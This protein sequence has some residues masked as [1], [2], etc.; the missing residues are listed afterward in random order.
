[1]KKLILLSF[2]LMTT[3]FVNAQRRGGN[4][5][6]GIEKK[7]ANLTTELN[8]STEQQTALKEIFIEQQ[9][10]RRAGGKNMRDLDQA[11]RAAMKAERKD[12]RAAADA[13]IAN[14]LTPAQLETFKH[15]E[16]EKKANRGERGAAKGDK[17]RGKGKGKGKAK[18]KGNKEKAT[19]EM[20]AQKRADKLTE[21]LGLNANQQ[22]AV[23]NLYL[24]EQPKAKKGK[25]GQLSDAEKATM[26][27]ERQQQKAAFEAELAQILTPAQFEQFQNMPKKGK[28]KGK[29]NKR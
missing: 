29:K 25:R 16:T 24:N 8:L 15:L 4:P 12:A 17:G 21:T 7:V 1:M 10:S 18:N 11:E 20:R 6:K 9:Q 22:T 27:A 28:K 23:Y 19:P 5:E 14:I 13:K 2:L 3:I 26:K